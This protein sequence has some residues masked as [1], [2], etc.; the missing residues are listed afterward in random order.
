[1]G[2]RKIRSNTPGACWRRGLDR[3]VP[4]FSPIPG[5]KCKRVPDGS[6]EKPP[7][8]RLGGFSMI[9][10][11][12]GT[13]EIAF[14]GDICCADDIR[15]RMSEIIQCMLTGST[16]HPSCLPHRG[17]GTA[18]RWRGCT[19]IDRTLPQ[20]ASLTAPSKRGPREVLL[21]LRKADEQYT[22]ISSAVGGGYRFILRILRPN[23]GRPPGLRGRPGRWFP[24]GRCWGRSSGA[25]RGRGGPARSA[26]SGPSSPPAYRRD[27]RP[28]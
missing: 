11:P 1:M 3:A 4:L 27:L 13:G 20:S 19:S 10:V 23:S 9:S 21:L 15:K 22:K 12:G 25:R 26:G 28:S 6:P 18:K 14:G 5:R 17:R 16:Q 24:A 8:R 7:S 2:T